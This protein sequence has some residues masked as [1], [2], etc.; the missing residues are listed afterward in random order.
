MYFWAPLLSSLKT[1]CLG[2]FIVDLIY[3]L[4][5]VRFNFESVYILTISP[6]LNE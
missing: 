3:Y 4:L 5:L 6:L 1:L 2:K